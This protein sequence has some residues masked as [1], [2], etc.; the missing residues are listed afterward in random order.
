MSVSEVRH[1]AR[2][3][4]KNGGFR[5]ALI[6]PLN[7]AAKLCGAGFIYRCADF[8]S[9]IGSGPLFMFEPGCH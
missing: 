3:Q 7:Y 1:I 2:N 9:C 6:E 5:A 8:Y 4:K